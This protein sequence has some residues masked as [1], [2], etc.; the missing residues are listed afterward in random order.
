MIDMIHYEMKRI[1][2]NKRKLTNF[3]YSSDNS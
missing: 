2:N 3:L 1:H